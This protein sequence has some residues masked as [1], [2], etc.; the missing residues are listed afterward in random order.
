M[1]LTQIEQSGSTISQTLAGLALDR[2]SWPKESR[3]EGGQTNQDAI[4]LVLNCFL[5]VNALQTASTLLLWRLD[6]TRRRAA[7]RRVS[8]ADY[9]SLPT[10]NIDDISSLP[11]EEESEDESRLAKPSE[12]N[13]ELRQGRDADAVSPLSEFVDEDDT[14]YLEEEENH[15]IARAEGGS[16]SHRSRPLLA[17]G[18]QISRAPYLLSPSRVSPRRHRNHPGLAKRSSEKKRAKIAVW[19][20][21]GLVACTWILFMGTAFVELRGHGR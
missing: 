18:S 7:Q 13:Q 17:K 11:I 15:R 4:Q 20:C 5:S 1:Q 6:F 16:W 19:S 8:V 3:K 10:V 9:Q 2:A 21:A 14:R 12:R